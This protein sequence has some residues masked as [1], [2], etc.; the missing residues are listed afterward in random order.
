MTE[1]RQST[2]DELNNVK[3]ETVHW[4]AKAHRVTQV[5]SDG[6]IIDT[7]GITNNLIGV[8][9]ISVGTSEVEIVI[10]G[11]TRSIRIRADTTNTGVIYIGKT[12]VLADGTNDFVRLESGDEVIIDY[13]DT[14]NALFA[15]SDTATQLINVGALL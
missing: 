2:A 10:T 14:T 15:I 7:D 13:D 11:T 4:P 9:D 1:N 3:Q 5:D 8:G 6:N 12:G